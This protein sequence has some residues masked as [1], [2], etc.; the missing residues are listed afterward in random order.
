MMTNIRYNNVMDTV[1]FEGVKEAERREELVK[2]HVHSLGYTP[3]LCSVVFGG[4]ED[5]ELYT[6]LK[7]EA[8][9][10]VGIEFDRISLNFSDEMPLLHQE[11]AGVCG[12]HDVQG[13]LVQKPTREKWRQVTGNHSHGDFAWWWQQVVSVLDSQKDIDCLTKTNL[14]LV[15]NGMWRIVPATVRAVL[16]ILELAFNLDEDDLNDNNRLKINRPL[17]DMKA[18]VVGRSEIVGRPLAA[19]LSQAGAMVELCG[20]KTEDLGVYTAGAKVVV[21][22]TGVPGLIKEDLVRPGA[23]II[24][25]GSPKA[26]VDFKGVVGDAAFITPVPGGVGPMTVVSLLENLVELL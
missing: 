19:V 7:M 23:I 15:Y 3:R 1:V 24:D 18:V 2:A 4:D 5:G 16:S 17:A 22:A 12:R 26:D 11:I 13:I 10:R 21:S 6:K 25:V 9:L 8:A 14:D 20:S